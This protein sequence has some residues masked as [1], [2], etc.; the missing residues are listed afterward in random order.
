[1]NGIFY[2]VGVGPGDPQLLTLKAIKC[3]SAC[4]VIAVP[5]SKA[6]SL[7][8]E[9]TEEEK[10]EIL[11]GCAAYQIVLPVCPEVQNK[12][13][14][15]LPMPMMKDKEKLKQIHDLCAHK[16]SEVLQM[17][18]N[19]AFITLGDPTVYSTCLYVQKRLVKMGLDTELIPGVPSF[20]A[21]AARMRM[22]LAENKEE[23]HII[24]ASYRVEESLRLPG[25]KVLMKAGRKMADVKRIVKEQKLSVKM[26]ENCG[27]DSE[28]VYESVDEIPE[29]TS[30][31]SLMIIKEE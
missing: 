28:R 10:E 21:A 7:E 2:G 22:G 9:F 18:K 24:P 23:I 17:G 26:V 14:L 8:P 13:K 15:Y 19:V 16:A 5:V 25:T 4:D 12:S 3:I 31:Y 11:S 29:E 20:C 30:Y 1:M 6:E 27:M